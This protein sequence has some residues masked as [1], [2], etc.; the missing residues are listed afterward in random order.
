M[1]QDFG[2]LHRRGSAG[3]PRRAEQH[4]RRRKER[5][6][7]YRAAWPVMSPG[8][9]MQDWVVGQDSNTQ[10][11]GDRLPNSTLGSQSF[12]CSL[13][14]SLHHLHSS[15]P[16]HHLELQWPLCTEDSWSQLRN[17]VGK[18][19]GRW[20]QCASGGWPRLRP[21]RPGRAPFGGPAE[22]W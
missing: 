7:S 8:G 18:E 4:T 22:T 2:G 1:N 15:R 17:K 3:R 6:A 9:A 14:H 21:P 13:T 10:E 5:K 20:A 16:T 12:A 11:Q 19:V